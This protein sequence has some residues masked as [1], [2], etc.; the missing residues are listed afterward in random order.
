MSTSRGA[1]SKTK[2]V[3]APVRL[4]YGRKISV[5]FGVTNYANWNVLKNGASDARELAERFKTGFN[6]DQT[7]VVT[8]AD[9]TKA[10]IERI[11]ADLAKC[12]EDD[13]ISITWSGHGAPLT[14][15]NGRDT[16][17]LVPVDAPHPLDVSNAMEFIG[18]K[19]LS[20]WADEY[21]R[22][23]HVVFLLDC[24]FSGLSSARGGSMSDG[25]KMM[26]SKHLKLRCRYVINAGTKDEEVSDG[27]GSNS[28]FVTAILQSKAGSGDDHE[29]HV[30]EL[31]SEICRRVAEMDVMQ[32]PTGGI[33]DGD[34]GG[35]AYL[36]LPSESKGVR[37]EF[38]PPSETAQGGI[39]P[40]RGGGSAGGGE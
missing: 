38:T 36:A 37:I 8:D 13:L 1:K 30:G 39:A 10:H 4:C 14:L 6:F 2:V 29:C 22:T 24:C 17:F 27:F 35:I 16:G 40:S 21:I 9:V 23:R 33:L 20:R 15:A 19:E 3:P 7:L 25:T 34:K 18:M 26:I 32:T 11:F 5:H 12:H 28:P 31:Q